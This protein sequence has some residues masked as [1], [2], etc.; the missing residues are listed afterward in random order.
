MLGLQENSDC[1]LIEEMVNN[2]TFLIDSVGH[3][4]NGNRSYYTTRSQPPFY[5]LMLKL[6]SEI[7][8]E[9]VWHTYEPAL[10]KEYNYWMEGA[11]ILS[12]E[13]PAHR[14]VVRMPDGCVLNR[15]WDDCP[16]PRSESY[17]EDVALARFSPQ[18][19]EALYRHIR[20]AAESGWD[21]SSCWFANGQTIETSTPPIL[22]W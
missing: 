15:Y 12:E 13:K 5:A 2:F 9:E 8:G 18:E 6:L 20:A 14:R 10:K 19:S 3:I 16:N 11:H 21:F 7:K 22:F 4:P 1:Q 17:I